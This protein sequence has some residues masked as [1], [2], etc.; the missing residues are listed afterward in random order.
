MLRGGATSFLR[1]QKATL[2]RLGRVG[3]ASSVVWRQLP[4]SSSSSATSTISRPFATSS[5]K[6]NGINSCVGPDDVDADMAPLSTP[7]TAGFRAARPAA[8]DAKL[9]ADTGDFCSMQYVNKHGVDASPSSA[10][11]E[12]PPSMAPPLD[13]SLFPTVADTSMK[14]L[15]K[16]AGE[17]GLRFED[18]EIP[19]PGVNDV[20]IKVLKT[21]I[22]GTDLHSELLRRFLLLFVVICTRGRNATHSHAHTHGTYA[23]CTRATQFG[24]GT[25][26]RKAQFQRP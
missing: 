24:I 1:A 25:P 8:V 18:V 20:L 15:V 5:S 4:S 17:V 21:A 10:D 26:G 19:A 2:R 11:A 16:S 14:A 23:Y 7:S 22:C 12:L 6:K 9:Q 3:P 13:L